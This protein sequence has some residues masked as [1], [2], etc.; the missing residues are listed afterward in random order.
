MISL[1]INNNFTIININKT[2]NN[3]Y[4]KFINKELLRYIKISK[5]L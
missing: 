1:I 3:H 2:A 4:N 5:N